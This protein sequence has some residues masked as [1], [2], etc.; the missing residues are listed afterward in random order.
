[1][2]EPTEPSSA[3]TTPV[4][5][6]R[7]SEKSMSFWDHL[8]ELRGV[9]FRSALAFAVAA[10][11]VCYAACIARARSASTRAVGRTFMVIW[12]APAMRPIATAPFQARS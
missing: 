9:L 11:V 8:N 2:S 5:A 3:E 1:M 6:V 10:G 12:N 4:A 7:R